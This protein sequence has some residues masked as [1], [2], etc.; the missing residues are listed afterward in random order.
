MKPASSTGPDPTT[1]QSTARTLFGVGSG[2]A[3]E[4]FDWALYT[5]FS[6]FF[7][8][9]FF[10]SADP[11]SNVM[12]TLAVYAVGFLA[13]PFG[14]L[15]FGLIA[16]KRG[17]KLSM[18]LALALA[19]FGSLVIG[20]C[21]NYHAIGA[22]ASVVLVV[23][24]LIQGLSYGG[25]IPSAQTYLAESVPSR[26]RGLWGSVIAFSGTC[27]QLAGTILAAVLSSV[28]ST[29]FMTEWGWRLPFVLGGVFGLY[30]LYIRTK[31]HE[32]TI[33]V[34]ETGHDGSNAA[35]PDSV[36]LAL[37]RR[38]RLLWQVIGMTGGFTLIYYL[39]SVATP[40][41]AITVK[42]VPAKS[43]LWA[44]VAALTV[45][46]VSLPL[47]GVLSDRVGRK[48]VL[49]LG[50]AASTALH[51][52]LSAM[53]DG[54]ALRLFVAMSAMLIFV[55]TFAALLPTVNAEIFPTRIRAL[56]VG[57]PYSFAIALFGGTAPYLQSYFGHLGKNAIFTG[58]VVVMAAVSIAVTLTIPETKGIDLQSEP[59]AP[60]RTA[61]EETGA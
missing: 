33:F 48:P 28:F 57:I 35:R 24:R 61:L 39:W 16:D 8:A 46:L 44:S 59:I 41:F 7:A 42:H 29:S 2:N 11:V 47:W 9:Q 30:A 37:A 15:L 4:W 1:R 49:I 21:P 19:A 25:E 36:W 6:P 26:R 55:G 20:L 43:A 23:A 32:T 18:A 53:L 54:S 22:A 34:A 27:G 52:P 12:S 14:G 31:L 56:G 50:I 58:Y 13:R 45:F 5:T 38:P 60:H 40:A 3:M 51:F 10:H 17:R